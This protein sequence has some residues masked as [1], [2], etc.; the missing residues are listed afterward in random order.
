VDVTSR[1]SLPP[2]DSFVRVTVGGIYKGEVFQ[3]VSHADAWGERP[4]V[5]VMGAFGCRLAF[6]PNEVEPARE[7]GAGPRWVR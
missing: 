4:G 3:V 5:W 6:R 7:Q 1:P 2:I